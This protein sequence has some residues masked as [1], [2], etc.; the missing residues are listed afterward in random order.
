M[1]FRFNAFNAKQ[2]TQPV[3][4]FGRQFILLFVCVEL[5]CFSSSLW[6]RLLCMYVPHGGEG[7]CIFHM[8]VQQ[9]SHMADHS[10]SSR[11]RTAFGARM[12]MHLVRSS[13][14]VVSL[15]VSIYYLFCT[16]DDNRTVCRCHTL[17]TAN[18]RCTPCFQ[19]RCHS[20]T[21][22]AG[23]K[24]YDEHQTSVSTTTC[25][26]HPQSSLH[27]AKTTVRTCI[28]HTHAMHDGSVL[29]RAGLRMADWKV[30]LQHLPPSPLLCVQ[31]ACNQT[32]HPPA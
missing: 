11:I 20:N 9:Y 15:L 10:A 22:H 29:R 32:R 28:E 16:Y 23:P 6:N 5:S 19:Q 25:N 4:F 17:P 21:I 1:L 7:T 18:P 14:T 2:Y 31:L 26:I 8:P 24:I 12:L 30:I 13:T 3:Y 27:L